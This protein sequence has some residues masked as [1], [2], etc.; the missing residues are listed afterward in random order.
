MATVRRWFLGKCNGAVNCN[1][2]DDAIT[3]QS[4]VLISVSEG[5]GGGPEGPLSSAAPGRF[6]GDATMSVANI[7]PRDGAVTFRIFVDWFEPLAVWVD[8]FIASEVPQG[9]AR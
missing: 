7:S 2:S 6:L 8:I 4:V 5:E 1:Y 9:F 3:N